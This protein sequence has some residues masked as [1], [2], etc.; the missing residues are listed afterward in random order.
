[1][2]RCWLVVLLLAGV[3]AWLPTWLVAAVGTSAGGA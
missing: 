3:R 1:M 2:H